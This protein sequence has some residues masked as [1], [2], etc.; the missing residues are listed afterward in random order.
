MQ[1]RDFLKLGLTSLGSIATLSYLEHA[2]ESHVEHKS[3]GE[4]PQWG[5]VIDVSK[6]TGCEH[7]VKACNA[8]NDINPDMAWNR[9]H[10]VKNQDGGE[11][12]TT[13]ACQHCEKAPCVTVC[14]V[15]ASYSR[16][17]GI[18]MMDYDQCIGCRYCQVAC[19]YGARSFNWDEFTGENPYVPDWGEPDVERRARGVVEKCTFCVQRIDRGMEAGL[20]PGVDRAATPVC[21]NACPSGARVFGDVTDPSSPAG[22]ALD[23]Y[24]SF[25]LLEELGA[26]PNVHYIASEGREGA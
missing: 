3:H 11:S 7:C 20:T 15:G 1:R 5:M 12:F 2:A 24:A 21:V 13:V 18:V 8:S 9:V 26:N 19:P 22:Q 23:K 25:K 14:P 16:E 6:C 17:D 4:G 10:T